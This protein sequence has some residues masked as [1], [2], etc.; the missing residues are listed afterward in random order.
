MLMANHRRDKCFDREK[1]SDLEINFENI[2][3]KYPTIPDQGNSL[4]SRD[5]YFDEEKSSLFC[6]SMKSVACS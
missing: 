1:F 6:P 2:P 5:N 3:L 4:A